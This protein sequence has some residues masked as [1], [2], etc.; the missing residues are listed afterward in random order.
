MDL[1]ADTIHELR[2]ALASG[3]TQPIDLANQALKSS[4][5]NI[6]RNVYLWQDRHWTLAGADRAF[7]ISSGKGGAFGDGREALW[8]LPV[9]VKDCFDLE[10][11]PTSAGTVFYRDR[12]GVAPRD[13]WLVEKLQGMGAVITG[14][15]HLHALAYGI[16]GENPEFG[17]C[18]QPG[19]KNALTGGSSSGAA[20]SLMEGSAVAAIGTDTGGSIRVPAALCGLAGYRSSLGRG[21]WRGGAH[22]AESFD[23]LGWLFRH[24]EDAPLMAA[25]YAPE[26]KQSNRRYSRFAYVGQDFLHDCDT[27]VALSFRTLIREMEELGLSG[28]EFDTSWWAGTTDIFAPL[29]ASEAAQLHAGNFE[30]FEPA[31]QQ[32]LAWGASLAAAEIRALREN[33]CEFRTRMDELFATHELVLLPSAPIS[34]LT[35]GAGDGGVAVRKRLL[36][37][38]SPFSLAGVPCVVIPCPAGGM[39]LAAAREDDESLLNL[40][41]RI[42]AKRKASK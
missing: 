30:H 16:T 3:K 28:S 33:H 17:D 39:Q 1:R 34:R 10:G 27:D 41:A 13:S 32:R 11:A 8:G 31:L 21:D 35:A 4:N 24:L 14:K 25:P 18:I 36:R 22:L 9:S 23:T 40:A 7:N 26:T 19:T 29:Q 37:Y 15:T 5:Q 20:A 38:T 42:G 6:G 12:N 2:R